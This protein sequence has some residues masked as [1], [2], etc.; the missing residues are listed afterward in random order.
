MSLLVIQLGKIIA[1]V[2]IKVAITVVTAYLIDVTTN[3]T[4]RKRQT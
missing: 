1:D 2:A 3:K 4:S